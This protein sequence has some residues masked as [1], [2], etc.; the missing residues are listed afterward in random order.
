MWV[1][2]AVWLAAAPL[3]AHTTSDAEQAGWLVDRYTDDD[4]LP[5]LALTGVAEAADGSL[6]LAS[7]AG[8]VRL[9]GVATR[10]VTRT[11]VPALPGNRYTALQADSERCLW[12]IEEH[13][14]LVRTCGQTFS[15][16]QPDSQ[17]QGHARLLRSV[18]GQLWLATTRG[19]MKLTAEGPQP[20]HAE[21]LRRPVG[22]LTGDGKGGIWAATLESEVWHLPQNGPAKRLRWPD[23][24]VR[25]G[26]HAALTEADGRVWFGGNFATLYTVRGNDLIQVGAPAHKL[27]DRPFRELF[28]EPDGVLVGRTDDT[29]LR[30]EASGWVPHRQLSGAAQSGEFHWLSQRFDGVWWQAGPGG[31]YRDRQLILRTRGKLRSIARDRRGWIWATSD[32]EGLI[33]L[34]ERRIRPVQAAT[35]VDP[36]IEVVAASDTGELWAANHSL[37]LLRGRPGGALEPLALPTPRQPEIR[38]LLTL[39]GGDLLTGANAGVAL[40]TGATWSSLELPWPVHEQ[41]SA[42]SLLVAA[43]G[44]LWV[45]TEGGLS[46]LPDGLARLRIA[47]DVR[48]WL[49]WRQV[50]LADGA[51]ISNGRDFAQVD[52]SNLLLATADQGLILIKDER[53]VAFPASAGLPTKHLRALTR[54]SDG[55]WIGTEDAGLCHLRWRPDWPVAKAEARCLGIDRGLAEDAVHAVLVGADQSL[56][57]SGNR[58]LSIVSRRDLADTLAS[59][60]GKVA[61]L[62]M[63]HRH[64]MPIRELNGRLRPALATDGRGMLWLPSQMGVVEV[65]TGS[66][67]WPTPP[68]V[69]IVEVFLGDQR[70]DLSKPLGVLGRDAPLRLSWS[71]A[72]FEWPD[73]VRFRY[74]TGSD[75]SWS[76]PTAERSAQWQSLGPGEHHLEVQ[77]GFGGLWSPSA[78]LTVYRPPAPF[79]R[80][81]FVPLVAV[82]MVLLVA[83]MAGWGLRRSKRRQAELERLVAS[84]TR[85]LADRNSILQAQGEALLEQGEALAN[86][87]AE[88]EAQRLLKDRMVANISH[89]LRTPLMLVQA[90]LERLVVAADTEQR[91]LLDIAS[92]NVQRLRELM[93]QLLLAAEGDA[94]TTPLSMKPLELTPFLRNI[95]H[96]FQPAAQDK[97]VEL[98]GIWPQDRAMVMADLDLM[99]KVVNNLLVN[100]LKFSP[101]DGQVAVELS[102]SADQ[103]VL[104]V[105]DTGIGIPAEAKLR[106]FERFYQVHAGDDR[107]AEG[108]GIGLSLAAELI[109]LMGGD[110]EVDS[111]PGVGSVFSV[112]L[113][114][115]HAPVQAV[116][117][118]DTPGDLT[119]LP[120]PLAALAPSTRPRILLVEDNPGLRQH[121]VEE[122]SQTYRITAAADGQAALA[123]MA[124][125]RP[126]VVVSDVMMPGMDGLTLCR[127][128]RADPHLRDIPVI[129]ASAKGSRTD[130]TAGLAVAQDYLVKPFSTESLTVR[131][132]RLLAD[133]AVPLAASPAEAPRVDDGSL[134][135]DRGPISAVEERFLQ[136]L[137]AVISSRLDD[138]QLAIPEIAKAMAVSERQLQREVRR[139]LGLAPLDYLQQVRVRFA[140][141]WLSTGQFSTVAEVAAAVGM[142]PRTLRRAYAERKGRSPSA[143]LPAGQ[144]RASTED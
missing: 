83:A 119:P 77:A 9:D 128:M 2:A 18:D 69:R 23:D 25:M 19:V 67:H 10:L 47:A 127:A 11:S 115:L 50:R 100:A 1:A 139:L 88:L 121:L 111:E 22:A 21:E 58:G 73:R 44:D 91:Q 37:Q 39:P 35:G 103:C 113:P 134:P 80:E 137:D 16:W 118:L 74:R 102:V 92:S 142:S 93:D 108:A 29:W 36:I 110:I 84:R 15:V 57:L 70:Q 64:G 141:Q 14:G 43:N 87:T 86:R 62:L 131:I 76:V 60:R 31:L 97:R 27:G 90:P 112:W 114:R 53:G 59:P 124:V 42:V 65:D 48:G 20:W 55:W 54:D 94:G 68:P 51:D 89:E 81:L 26:L 56:W 96:Q 132:A 72:E 30:W 126:D 143:D 63:D 4:G 40:Y 129:F 8:L 38:T 17:L 109:R 7:F 136:R 123:A 98:A 133:S 13:G 52:S 117:E 34:R 28:R 5:S 105:R 45:A 85:E 107:S 61:P 99:S 49:D 120:H 79:E 75:Q 3:W 116:A 138:D 33:C 24:A 144:S 122:L 32:G 46:L 101:A 6:W 130:L 125:V 78:A 12:A 95:V 106:I 82:A 41:R 66:F 71:S 140:E 104:S 135:L